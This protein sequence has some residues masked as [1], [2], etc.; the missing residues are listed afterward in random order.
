MQGWFNSE[1][2]TISEICQHG[3][4]EEIKSIH[5]EDEQ[6]LQEADEKGLTALH[7]ASRYN[8]RDI[9]EYLIK[10]CYVDV[11]VVTCNDD[12][13]PLHLAVR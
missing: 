9:I 6:K 8:Q 4:L 10:S 12:V 2:K 11:N 5:E 3:L 7:Y 13:T 1:E